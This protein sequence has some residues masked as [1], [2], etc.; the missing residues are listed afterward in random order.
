[1]TDEQYEL[2]RNESRRRGLGLAERAGL[3]ANRYLPSHPEVDPVDH[4]I[5]ATVEL[6]DAVLW[7]RNLEHLP[8]FPDLQP[9]Y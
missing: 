7:T 9:P 5:A 8:M 3:L 6:H 2:L 1:M 4:I